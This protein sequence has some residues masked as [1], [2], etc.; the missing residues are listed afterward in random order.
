MAQT[1]TA[2][3]RT[4]GAVNRV[5][6]AHKTLQTQLPKLADRERSEVVNALAKSFDDMLSVVRAQ[7][8]A[9]TKFDFGDDDTID[10]D[11]GS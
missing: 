6:Q 3:K 8:D 10:A 7:T 9:N 4:V 11:G 2:K 1:K 5:M